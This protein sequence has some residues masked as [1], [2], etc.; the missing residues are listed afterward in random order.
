MCSLLELTRAL[1]L[2]VC[3]VMASLPVDDPLAVAAD[4]CAR[5]VVRAGTIS[6]VKRMWRTRCRVRA[7]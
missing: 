5:L 3:A 1:D 2:T 7:T 4:L 6:F